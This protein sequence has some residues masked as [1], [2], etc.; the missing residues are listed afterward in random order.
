MLSAQ[1]IP[2][3]APKQAA[4]H[5]NKLECFCFTQQTLKANES[6]RMP[7]VFVIENN[8]YSMGTSQARSS[9]GELAKRAEGYNMAWD[10]ING[11]DVYEVRAKTALALK[12]AHEESK[13]TVLEIFTYRYFG[14]SLSDPRTEYRT[15]DEEEAWKAADPIARLAAA[16]AALG[17]AAAGQA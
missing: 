11:H 4:A 2:S 7:V 1:A 3:Y 14:H 17:K 12:R 15:K 9:A 10:V 8:G 13:P 16:Q 5:F 6:R